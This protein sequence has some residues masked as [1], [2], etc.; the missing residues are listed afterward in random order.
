MLEIKGIQRTAPA[1]PAVGAASKK[2]ASAGVKGR[3]GH[4]HA[5]TVI[6][7]LRGLVL[8]QAAAFNQD[9]AVLLVEEFKGRGYACRA[10][11]DNA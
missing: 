4:A 1:G 11:T 8:V 5:L 9:D 7:C 2:A 3:I 10:A 6:Q